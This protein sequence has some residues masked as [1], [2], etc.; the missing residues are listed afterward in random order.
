[1]NLQ[2]LLKKSAVM[3]SDLNRATELLRLIPHL[4]E[5]VFTA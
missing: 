5:N 4:A 2:G 3:L 1:M